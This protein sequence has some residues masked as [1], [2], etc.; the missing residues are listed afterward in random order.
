MKNKVPLAPLGEGDLGGEGIFFTSPVTFSSACSS[1][2]KN[3]Q[4]H[5]PYIVS[6]TLW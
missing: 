5:S 1:Y 6:K 2:V 3:K 4:Y